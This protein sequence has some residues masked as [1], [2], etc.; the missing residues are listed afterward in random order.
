MVLFCN[1]MVCL[2]FIC[3]NCFNE[4][5]HSNNKVKFISSRRQCSIGSVHLLYQRLKKKNAVMSM[6]CALDLS[7]QNSSQGNDIEHYK[8]NPFQHTTNLQQTTLKIY[9]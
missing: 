1:L 6:T 4:Q 9:C 8:Y 3:P 5:C 2:A 7:T